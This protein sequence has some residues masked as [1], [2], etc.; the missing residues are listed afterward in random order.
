MG[1]REVIADPR[2]QNADPEKQSAVLKRLGASDEF[3][4][5]FIE[6]GVDK[7]TDIPYDLGGTA[8]RKPSFNEIYGAMATGESEGLPAQAKGALE[9]GALGLGGELV[10]PALGAVGVAA[11]AVPA[12]TGAVVGAAPK[13]M[14]GDVTGALEHG[15]YGAMGMYGFGKLAKLYRVLKSLGLAGEETTAAGAATRSAAAPGQLTQ[16]DMLATVR[17]ASAPTE[18][19]VANP[20]V[21]TVAEQMVPAGGQGKLVHDLTHAGFSAEQAT[22]IAANMAKSGAQATVAPVVEATAPAAAEAA[23]VASL[24]QRQEALLAGRPNP[25]AVETPVYHKGM[26]LDQKALE[27]LAK[28]EKQYSRAHNALKKAGAGVTEP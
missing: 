24:A 26:R 28:L 27:E 10:A 22:A 17:G 7:N 15:A 5:K 8:K 3:V 16:G 20:S 14:R 2:F 25:F 12:L 18:G 13:L 6:S 11:R 4:N 19:F 23:P 9:G 1:L 21:A